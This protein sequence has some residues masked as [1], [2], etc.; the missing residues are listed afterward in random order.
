MK[1][2]MDIVEKK[3]TFQEHVK[4]EM[5]FNSFELKVEKMI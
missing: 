1:N 2:R 4:R 5:D 3:Q